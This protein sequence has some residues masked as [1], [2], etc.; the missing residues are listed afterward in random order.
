MGPLHGEFVC[1][2]DNFYG[3]KVRVVQLVMCDRAG[4]FPGHSEFDHDYMDPRQR[5]FCDF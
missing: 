4:R 2:A 5:L 3:K 1:Q